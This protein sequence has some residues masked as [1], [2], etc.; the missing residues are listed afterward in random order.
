VCAEYIYEG[1]PSVLCRGGVVYS[2]VLFNVPL[3]PYL[4]PP[5]KMEERFG[6]LGVVSLRK[7]LVDLTESQLTHSR[8]LLA[9]LSSL[10]TQLCI[11][12]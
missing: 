10:H 3:F 6:R 1:E 9:Q 8:C 11:I 2:E 5:T 7:S 4:T 12:T